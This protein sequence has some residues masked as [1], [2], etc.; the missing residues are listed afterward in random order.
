[1]AARLLWRAD[2]RRRPHRGLVWQSAR[3]STVTPWW[4]RSTSSARR[5]PSRPRSRIIGRSTSRSPGISRA[6][7]RRYAAFPPIRSCCKARTGST[8]YNYVTDK[9]A[10]TLRTTTPRPERSLL[11][12]RQ[13]AGLDRRTSS[14]QHPRLAQTA[15]GSPGPSGAYSR[16]FALTAT[17]RWSAI[18]TI[19]VE[20]PTDADRLTKNPLGV[21]VHALN[22]S[23]ELG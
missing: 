12:N 11:Q 14:G 17:E 13:D 8:P 1:M 6:S 18:I 22:W 10:L 19:V 20:P 23:K 4:S 15:S 16:R 21:Y 7:S 3:A 5:K 2:P 9:G